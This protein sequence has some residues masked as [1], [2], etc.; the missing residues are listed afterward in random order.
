M[1]TYKEL[2]QNKALGECFNHLPKDPYLSDLLHQGDEF[3][4]IF[5]SRFGSV[6]EMGPAGSTDFVSNNPLAVS[7]LGAFNLISIITSPHLLFPSSLL[8]AQWNFN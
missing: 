5:G 7:P 1:H 3:A 8:P 6:M 4:N 2:R